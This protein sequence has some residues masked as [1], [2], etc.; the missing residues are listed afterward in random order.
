MGNPPPTFFHCFYF[1][2][3][4]QIVR[5]EREKNTDF[6]VFFPSGWEV[7]F[8]HQ[9]LG[10]G[11]GG[12]RPRTNTKKTFFWGKKKCGWLFL[13]GGWN[14]KKV[15]ECFKK[16]SFSGGCG[17][18]NLKKPHRPFKILCVVNQQGFFGPP[19]RLFLFC[20]GVVHP[21]LFWVLDRFEG[22]KQPSP[23]HGSIVGHNKK[24]K[25]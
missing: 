23:P 10:K 11:K 22:E 12:F 9:K 2:P 24:L 5:G 21:P 7:I 16:P 6:W 14:K 25:G 8:K 18:V 4:H 15:W 19:P 1:P 20:E 17:V 13:W 3:T